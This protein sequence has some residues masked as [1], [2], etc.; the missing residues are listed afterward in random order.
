[1]TAFGGGQMTSMRRE[2]V[3]RAKWLT[4][5]EF[6][7][8]VSI[9]SVT[10][11]PNPI[12]LSVLVGLRFHGVLGAATCLAATAFPA[13]VMLMAI[14][15]L[16]YSQPAN[17][18]IHAVFRGCAAAV[19]GINIA[20][21]YEMTAPYFRAPVALAFILVTALAV[22]L[23]HVRLEVVMLVLAPLSVALRYWRGKV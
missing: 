14:A 1:M 15:A 17:S 20:N 23:F 13:F 19:V 9:G 3:S 6:V 22:V 12:N 4:N 7:E 10:P 8:L 16:Y 11:G 2:V 5:E 21:A 18:P